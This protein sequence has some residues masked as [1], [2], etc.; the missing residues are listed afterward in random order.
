MKH[1]FDII[2]A[3]AHLGPF[4]QFHIANHGPSGLIA[5]MDRLG[6][7]QMWISAHA[8][9]SADAERGNEEVAEA[10][11]AFPGRFLGYVVVDP[12]YPDEVRRELDRR[13]AQPEFAMIKLHPALME[14]P[15]DGPNY[16]PVWTCARERRCPVLTHA[17]TGCPYC[18][19]AKVRRVLEKHPDIRIIFGHALFQATF[20][21][22]A[23]LAQDFEN[24]ILDITTSNH[25]Y[26]MIAHAVE[27]IGAD[28]IVYG[29]D[30]PFISAA[31]GIGK[32]LYAQISDEDKA[33]IL[34]GN[35]QRLLD[36]IRT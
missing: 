13:L 12:H 20:N 15:I 31:G 19:P 17:W 21:E 10:A 32:V 8:A 6:I 29:S 36:E 14:Y 9:I 26:G 4:V 22:A 23:A 30:M 35:A 7:R 18:G 5:E 25:G 3:H 33:K 11:R 28:R 34:G 24:L 2:D 16:D 27:T 1:P